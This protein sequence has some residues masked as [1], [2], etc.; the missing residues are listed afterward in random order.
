MKRD[1]SEEANDG[2]GARRCHGEISALNQAIRG[3]RPWKGLQDQSDEAHRMFRVKRGDADQLITCRSQPDP[4]GGELEK[5]R[6]LSRSPG[7]VC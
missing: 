7:S 3:K 1:D 5:E 6:R 4:G 2:G